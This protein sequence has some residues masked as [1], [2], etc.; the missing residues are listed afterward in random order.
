MYETIVIGSGP[1][2]LMAASNLKNCLVLEKN[3]IPAKKL[4]ITGGGRCNLTNNKKDFIK[5][6][7][8]N[9]FFNYSFSKFNNFDVLNYFSSVKLKNEGFKVYPVSNSS[10]SIIDFLI[11]N[12]N[13]KYDVNVLEI[14]KEDVFILNTSSGVFTCNNLVIATGGNS[15]KSLGSTGD[16]LVFAKSLGHKIV[17][18][19]PAL[20]S[21]YTNSLKDL[22][23]SSF[24]VTLCNG[25]KTFTDSIIVT[26]K[27]ISGPAAF[28]ISEFVT[29]KLYVNFLPEFDEGKLLSKFNSFNQSLFIKSFVRSLVSEKLADFLI[30]K[31][32]IDPELKLAS[33]S[34]KLRTILFDMLLNFELVIES[35]GSL[36]EAVV[37]GGGVSVLDLNPK[38]MESLIVPNL[39]FAGE[40]IDVHGPTGGYNITIALSTG[41]LVSSSIASKNKI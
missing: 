18:I 12:I 32:N 16:G 26:H 19:Y 35:K 11:R 13:I 25:D 34:K 3:S 27:G 36:D 29:S 7:K 24:Y 14:K 37:T 6:V 40:V 30:S 21:L 15:Y 10:K 8:N 1:A 41:K 28:A 2:G 5:D 23:G 38:T 31:S 9:D 4:S 20:V 17:P 22:V 33:L 39:Y